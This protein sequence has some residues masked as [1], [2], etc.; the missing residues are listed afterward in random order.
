MEINGKEVR[1]KAT[2]KA[3]LEIAEICPDGDVNKIGELFDKM[4][5]ST[6]KAAIKVITA[7]S[8]GTL[9]EDEIM[10]FDVADLQ[11]ILNTAM[12]SFKAD[13]E[14]TVKVIAK[15]SEATEAV[16]E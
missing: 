14:P 16:Q 3:V 13:Q 4:D 2:I 6:L 9:T 7:L 1:F 10:E 15:K 12:A 8:N 5:A 11:D